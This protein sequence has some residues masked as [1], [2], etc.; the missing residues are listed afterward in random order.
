MDALK[1]LNE[2]R[3]AVPAVKYALAVAGI[4][5]AASIVSALVGQGRT[6][7]LLVGLVFVGMILVF[8]FST[9]VASNSRSVQIAGEV[10]LWAVLLFFI[11]FLALTVSAFL[12]N[13]PP[14]W[15]RFLG[16]EAAD[17][18]ED[19][20]K[21]ANHLIERFVASST[22]ATATGTKV[23]SSPQRSG[24]FIDGCI[25]SPLF[26]TQ[27]GQQCQEEAQKIVATMY[28]QSMGYRQSMNHVAKMHPTIHSSYVLVIV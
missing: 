15:V 6:A 27:F 26:P 5:A 18:Q 8:L 1:I 11:T 24:R 19:R 2:A 12:I 20:I 22:P 17:P 23:F 21:R 13:S 9:L 25:V 14:A 7:L 16:I 10:L 3:K 28:C 4:A